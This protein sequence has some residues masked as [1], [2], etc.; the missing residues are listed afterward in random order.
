MSEATVPLEVQVMMP[1][2]ELRVVGL[3]RSKVAEVDGGGV[4]RHGED[5]VAVAMVV[6]QHGIFCY[7]VYMVSSFLQ[8]LG[9]CLEDGCIAAGQVGG[10]DGSSAYA[11]NGHA[12]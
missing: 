2:R 12:K 6:G 3:T 11:K 1:E 7:A 8:L 5:A 10:I 9:Y 4:A